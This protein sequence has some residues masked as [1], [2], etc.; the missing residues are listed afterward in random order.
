MVT[1][2]KS[3]QLDG[4]E[5]VPTTS[6]AQLKKAGFKVTE[7]PG[8]AFDD[9]IINDNPKQDASHKELLNP[10]LRQ[11]FDDAIDRTQIVNTSLLGYGAPGST[12]IPPVTGNWSDPSIKPAA[13]DLAKANQLLDQ[14]GYKM[15]SNGVRVADGHPMTYTVIMPSDI[16]EHLRQP[17]VRDHPGGVQAD[18]RPADADGPGPTRPP[19]PRSPRTT[20][21]ASSCR[22][23]TGIP[24]PTRTSCSR[25]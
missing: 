14:A 6:V 20:T 16:T 9:F 22:C 1:A 10:L 24:R 3:G 13:Y 21:R 19:T 25:C 17:V 11:A 7:T 8:D 15:G 4:V 23:G 18:R 12:I 5:T 2:L